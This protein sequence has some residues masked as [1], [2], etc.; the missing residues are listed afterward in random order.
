MAHLKLSRPFLV[1]L[2]ASGLQ[3]PSEIE[4]QPPSGLGTMSDIEVLTCI[5]L[6]HK[7]AQIVQA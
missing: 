6:V 2:E 5:L 1:A 3:N 4:E 7:G